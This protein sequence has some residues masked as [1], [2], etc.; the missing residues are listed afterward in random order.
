M[1]DASTEQWS[2]L[3]TSYKRGAVFAFVDNDGYYTIAGGVYD[4]TDYSDYL[5]R[6]RYCYS[7]KGIA[8]ME[9]IIK[10]RLIRIG[11]NLTNLLQMEIQ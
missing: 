10:I 5:Y 7:I 9:T 1:F 2:E 6:S 8:C 3:H 4:G 11:I